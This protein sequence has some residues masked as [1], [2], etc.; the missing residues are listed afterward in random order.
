MF[1]NKDKYK[2]E[3]LRI[4]GLAMFAPFGKIV[5]DL[6]GFFSE[7]HDFILIAYITIALV[8]CTIGLVLINRG[9]EIID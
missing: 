1:S 8:G 2:A 5:L 3:T 6:N 4:V 9:L 7:Y